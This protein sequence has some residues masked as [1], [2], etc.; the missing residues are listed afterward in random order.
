MSV[1][2]NAEGMVAVNKMPLWELYQDYEDLGIFYVANDGRATLIGTEPW[3][4]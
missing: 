3:E 1:P 2:M 4:D